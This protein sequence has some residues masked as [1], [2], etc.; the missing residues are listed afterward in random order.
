MALWGSAVHT[1]PPEG[2]CVIKDK[3]EEHSEEVVKCVRCWT[4]LCTRHMKTTRCYLSAAG[5]HATAAG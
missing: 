5:H 3:E 1:A 4:W 2:V